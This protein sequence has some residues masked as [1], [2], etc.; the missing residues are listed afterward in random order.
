M[1]DHPQ[2]GKIDMAKRRFREHLIGSQRLP[3]KRKEAIR[4]STD[5]DTPATPDT[6]QEPDE[7]S[8]RYQNA[9]RFGRK[10]TGWTRFI[11]GVPAA[12]LFLASIVLAVSTFIDMVATTIECVAEGASLQ[13]MATEYIEFA[14]IFLLAVVLYIMALGLFT[15]FVS[16][17]IPLPHWLEFHDFDDLKERLGSVI[18]VMLGVFFLGV[19]MKG[20]TGIDLVWLGLASAIIIA[21]LTLF[22]KHVIKGD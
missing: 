20:T 13:M 17:K 15:L 22:V 4:M 1:H 11:A 6:I 12:G 7:E 2:K 21:A 9:R 14:D 10:V 18:C 3:A 8:D 16:D 5:N 19:V